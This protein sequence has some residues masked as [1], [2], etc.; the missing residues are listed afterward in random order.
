MMPVRPWLVPSD[1]CMSACFEL[2]SFG[3]TTLEPYSSLINLLYVYPISLKY[4][5]Q[6][7]FNKARNI[8]CS[9]KFISA[10]TRG[11]EGDKAIYDRFASPTPFVNS[12]RCAIQHHEQNPTFSDEIKIQLPVSLDFTDHLL[13]T[14]THISVAGATASKTP[15]E[16]C[17]FIYFQ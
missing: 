12:A 16:V 3:D 1:S 5:S 7:T 2:Q 4:D 13:F 14:F 11:C 6:K 8:A 10:A 17:L 9:V 15:N